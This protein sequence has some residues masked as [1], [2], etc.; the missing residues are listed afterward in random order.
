MGFWD[1]ISVDQ[2]LRR[3]TVQFGGRF[4][5]RLLFVWGIDISRF[6]VLV[7]VTV[8]LVALAAA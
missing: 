5:G 4:P 7:A 6:L 8:L 1:L 2:F 3:C